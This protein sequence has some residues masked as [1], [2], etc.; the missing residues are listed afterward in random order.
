MLAEGASLTYFSV[1]LHYNSSAIEVQTFPRHEEIISE[2][3]PET[4]L[5][6]TNFWWIASM[7]KYSPT[8]LQEVVIR[9]AN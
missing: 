5:C 1:I 4:M 7:V 2:P 8:R 6:D 9:M 3:W